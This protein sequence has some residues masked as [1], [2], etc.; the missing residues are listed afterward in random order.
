MVMEKWKGLG[1]LSVW[2]LAWRIGLRM[3]DDNI[4]GYAAQLSYYFLFGLFPLLLILITIFGFFADTGSGL[5]QSLLEYLS[6]VM[7]ASAS[8]LIIQTVDEIG[9]SASGWKLWLGI[10]AALWAASNGLGAIVSGLNVAYGIKET[11]P[12]WKVRLISLALTL[13][14]SGLILVGLTL[15]FY[16]GR[17]A[18]AVA[19]DHG[20]GGAFT[21]GWHLAQWPL[22]FFVVLLFFSAIYYFAPAPHGQRWH[23]INPGALIGL[24]VWLVASFGFRGYLHYYNSYSKTYGS[25]GAVIV[26]LLWFYLMGTA[27]LLGGEINAVMAEAKQVSQIV[28]EP[29][30]AAETPE[31]DQ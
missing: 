12:W 11:R 14:L 26:L 19:Q 1:G 17:I 22:I 18:T 16:G 2:Q 25:L 27:I 8:G 30:P 20:F 6:G 10:L 7:P 9:N 21:L 29:D 15:F 23:F 3:A 13:A 28:G 4:F 31:P 5:R 24:I